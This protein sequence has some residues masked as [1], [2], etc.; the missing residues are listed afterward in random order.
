MQENQRKIDI[1]MKYKD[2]MER[3]KAVLGE[4]MVE[5]IKTIQILENRGNKK[6]EEIQELKEK[7]RE[8]D[9]KYRKMT[10]E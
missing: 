2:D 3:D 6:D 1:L 8:L 10:Y 5:Q 7:I 9:E 4:Q